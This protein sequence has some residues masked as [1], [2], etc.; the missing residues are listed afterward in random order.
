MTPTEFKIRRIQFN[1]TQA[2]L[3]NRLCVTEQTIR[4]WEKGRRR[5]PEW[6]QKMIKQQKPNRLAHPW[7]HRLLAELKPL[8]HLSDSPES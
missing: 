3:A 4:N 6:A 2:T 1:L 8:A 7:K 5:L